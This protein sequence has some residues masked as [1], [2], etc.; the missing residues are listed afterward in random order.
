VFW[1]LFIALAAG[2]AG[3][4]LIIHSRGRLSAVS[5]ASLALCWSLLVVLAGEAV[6]GIVH[7]I[8]GIAVAAILLIAEEPLEEHIPRR[9]AA[10]PDDPIAPFFRVMATIT[11][12]VIAYGLATTLPLLP[13]STL[14]A[15]S[16][17]WYWSIVVALMLLLLGRDRPRAVCGLLLLSTT[18]PSFYSV[19]SPE[20]DVGVVVF[21]AA[22][23]IALALLSIQLGASA[24]GTA[25][26]GAAGERAR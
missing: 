11:G 1:Q 23:T 26:G 24:K 12:A 7:A 19:V 8:T 9:R 2:M 18:G 20:E 3:A 21:G 22:V 4:A 5:F 17:A 6:V 25:S 10:P 15:T 14:P 13:S 16:F